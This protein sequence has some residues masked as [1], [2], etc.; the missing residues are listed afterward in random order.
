VEI[1]VLQGEREMAADNKTLGRFML[2]G[3][4]PAPRGVPQ[5]EVSFDIDANGILS[6]KAKDKATGKEQSI[7][8]EASTGLSKEEVEKMT[9]EAEMHAEEDKKK[10]DAV[11]A[12]NLADTLVY[13]TEKALREAGEKISADKKKPVEEKIAALKK[14]K[15]GDDTAAIKK[16][17]EELSQEA[18]KIGQELYSAAAKASTDKQAAPE[19]DKKGESS[20]A[21]ATADE[22][23]EGEVVDEKNEE[24]K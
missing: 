17:T 6:V 20:S 19:G 5:I 14:I 15:D 7:R 13:T 2:D 4:P 18:Q 12:R 9:K 1:H 8:I 24:K 22:V 23:K 16:A 3:I 10:K 21:K 11:E